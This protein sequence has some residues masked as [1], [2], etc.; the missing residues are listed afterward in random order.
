MVLE[1]YAQTP[2]HPFRDVSFDIITD[3]Y[4]YSTI[5]L[6]LRYNVI[7]LVKQ[8]DISPLFP[9]AFQFIITRRLQKPDHNKEQSIAWASFFVS[10]SYLVYETFHMYLSSKSNEETLF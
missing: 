4:V 9:D 7:Y 2:Y 1:H 5:G 6:L 8:Y 10:A 3:M